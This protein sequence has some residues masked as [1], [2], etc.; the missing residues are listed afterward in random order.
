MSQLDELVAAVAARVAD[1]TVQFEA[2][3]VKINEHAQ[4]RKVIFVRTNGSLKFSSA[5][6][7]Q[8]FGIPVGGQGTTELRRFTRWET[9]AVTMRAEDE[10]A[11]DALFDAVV[12]AIFDVG[13]P[14]VFENDNPYDWA[15]KDSQTAG[16]RI[17]RN[18]ELTFYF[19]MQLAS[20]PK[21]KPYAVIENAQ[22]TITELGQSV[23]IAVPG[24]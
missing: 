1:A 10:D 4:R 3:K 20:H 22:A 19:K 9:V 8:P 2:G 21:L 13:G 23:A 5:P 17:A 24:P 7:R 6:G 12:N 18:P 11:L 14:N 15:G 16:Q